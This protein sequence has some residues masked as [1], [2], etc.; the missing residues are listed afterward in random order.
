MLRVALMTILVGGTAWATEAKQT[1]SPAGA[2]AREGVIDPRADA[3]LRRMSDY[4]NSMKSFRVDATSVDE[5]ITTDGQKIQE[6]QQS[7]VTVRRPG[8]LR[9]DR[10]SPAGR[11]VF[12]DDGK[13]FSL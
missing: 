6:I 1:R 3:A 4:L 12:R 5:K 11:A 7:K 8:E 2:E 10:V 13:R 9:V